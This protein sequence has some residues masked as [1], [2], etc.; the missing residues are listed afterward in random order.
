MK[1][2]QTPSMPFPAEEESRVFQKS[3]IQHV[4]SK[5]HE[6]MTRLIGPDN[7]LTLYH[8]KKWTFPVESNA[9]FSTRD[10]EA[11]LR[12][13]KMTV[14][15]DRLIANDLTLLTEFI[16]GIVA[17]FS[18][19]HQNDSLALLEK[20]AQQEGNN[21]S[22]LPGE[23]LSDLWLRMLQSAVFIV[24][25]EGNIVMPTFLDPEIIQELAAEIMTRGEAFTE[26]VKKVKER[27]S[28]AAIAREDARLAKYD[29]E[30]VEQ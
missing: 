3:S 28:K 27:K 9:G 6:Q 11:A 14:E 10:G 16:D 17:G 1:S 15:V 4:A 29:E 5:L 19:Q 21:I 18:Q 7:F 8:G 12:S 22:R 24:N 25:R 13:Q 26:E 20:A 23:S 30:I 2:E